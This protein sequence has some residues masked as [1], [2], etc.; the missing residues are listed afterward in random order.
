MPWV[1]VEANSALLSRRSRAPIHSFIHPLI[2]QSARRFYALVYS[3]A[4]SHPG[5]VVVWIG[6]RTMRRLQR[7]SVA[8]LRRGITRIGSGTPAWLLHNSG[9]NAWAYMV[10]TSLYT[11][12]S[13]LIDSSGQERWRVFFGGRQEGGR[14]GHRFRFLRPLCRSSSCLEARIE[15]ARAYRCR[16]DGHNEVFWTPPP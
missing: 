2:Q 1:G 6:R 14:A 8:G 10:I 5:W 13:F 12:K 3:P 16:H 4:T 15:T 11:C 7:H 9:G